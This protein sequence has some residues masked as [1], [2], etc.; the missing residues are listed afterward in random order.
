V[1]LEI[2]RLDATAFA[3]AAE[4]L[5]ELLV[6]AVAGGASVGFLPPFRHVEA[7]AWWRTLQQDVATGAVVVLAASLED[8]IVGTV[9]LRLA[10][11][12]NA[13]HRAEV[14]K[15]LVDSSV[16]RRGVGRSLMAEI[17]RVARSAARTLLVLD[18][19]VDSDAERLYE[20]L[21]WTRVASIPEY[22]MHDGQLRPT[23]IFCRILT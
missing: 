6:D 14:P 15:L 2:V 3:R 23:T 19:I 12:P 8:R 18:T 1:S 16:R 10:Q 21:G 20:A 7:V 5:A 11:W 9:Q 22:A 13:R 17:E 4:P